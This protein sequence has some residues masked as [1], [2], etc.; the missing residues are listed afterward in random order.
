MNTSKS[1]EILVTITTYNESRQT[2][3]STE[4][5]PQKGATIKIFYNHFG[6][7]LKLH[8]QSSLFHDDW[9]S[10]S[11]SHTLS[12]LYLFLVCQCANEVITRSQ[13]I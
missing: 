4:D 11:K 12:L 9:Q 13:D 8:A 2:Y 6:N 10:S 1:D 5:V 3:L 7:S